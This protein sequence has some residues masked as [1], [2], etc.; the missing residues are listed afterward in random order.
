MAMVKAAATG[1]P[2]ALAPLWSVHILFAATI[3]AF[4][5]VGPLAQRPAAAARYARATSVRDDASAIELASAVRS[6]DSSGAGEAVRRRG[7][8]HGHAKKHCGGDGANGDECDSLS[9]NAESGSASH[10]SGES[11]DEGGRRTNAAARRR[12][13]GSGGGKLAE[14]AMAERMRQLGRVRVVSRG[15]FLHARLRL[16]LGTVATARKQGCLRFVVS[17]L[18]CT[19]RRA[20]RAPHS[21]GGASRCSTTRVRLHRLR[22]GSHGAGQ[23]NAGALLRGRARGW[24]R[25]KHT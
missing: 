23:P 2:H 9:S 16:C 17:V 7:G 3:S 25:G 11:G 13:G 24:Q 5:Y 18:Y 15:H 8:A 4:P 19:P 12:R 10:D 21:L 22:E 20:V 14:R 1:P 6:E